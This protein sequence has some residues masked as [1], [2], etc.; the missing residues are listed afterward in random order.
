MMISIDSPN[1][2]KTV[3][4][5]NWHTSFLVYLN[6]IRLSLEQQNYLSIVEMLDVTHTKR[7]VAQGEYDMLFVMT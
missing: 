1:F 2:L 7:F 4:K 3:S 5:L 6:I